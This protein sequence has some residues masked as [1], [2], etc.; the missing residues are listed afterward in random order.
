MRHHLRWI[1]GH[2]KTIKRCH[3]IWMKTKLEEIKEK[4][5]NLSLENNFINNTRNRNAL[6][7]IK[8]QSIMTNQAVTIMLFLRCFTV[9]IVCFLTLNY[10]HFFSKLCLEKYGRYIEIWYWH[11]SVYFETWRDPPSFPNYIFTWNFTLNRM[12]QHWN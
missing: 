1:R 7:G 12:K 3:E 5:R 11:S 6:Q 8:V 4:D 2:H 10:I 9:A